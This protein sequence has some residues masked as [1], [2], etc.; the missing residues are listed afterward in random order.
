MMLKALSVRQP[1]ATL[2]VKANREKKNEAI[3]PVE[4]RDWSS[5]YRGP[6]LIHS[7]KTF[8]DK[9]YRWIIDNID[10]LI[11]S[12]WPRIEY[13]QWIES[14]KDWPRGKLIGQVEMIDCVTH[15]SSPWFFGPWGHLYENPVQFE[16][17][18][19]LRGMPGIFDVPDTVLRGAR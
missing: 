18:V 3:K 11:E 15:H 1:W 13:E 14:S 7:A 17:P 5:Y 9:G 16:K 2:L 4:N 6:L 8:D 19:S 12:F 10:L